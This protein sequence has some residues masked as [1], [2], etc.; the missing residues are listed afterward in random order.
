MEKKSC[1]VAEIRRVNGGVMA[2]VLDIEE[3]VLRLIC[4]YTSHSGR[5]LEEKAFC[6]L[7]SEWSMHDVDDS[8]VCLVDF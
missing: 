8:A 2:V 4:G 1:E 3:D 5:S 7:K 6:V